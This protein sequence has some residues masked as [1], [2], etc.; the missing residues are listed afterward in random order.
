MI[1]LIYGG[2]IEWI[3]QNLIA[4][5]VNLMIYIHFILY[6]LEQKNQEGKELMAFGLVKSVENNFLP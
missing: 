3:L 6:I 2:R 1:G 5:G 4:P